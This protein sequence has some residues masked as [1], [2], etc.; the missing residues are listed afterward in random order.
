VAGVVERAAAGATGGAAR[1][2]MTCVGAPTLLAP[3]RPLKIVGE[4][5]SLFDFGALIR[6]T[7]GNP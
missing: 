7:P 5:G 1:R 3:T 6:S 4:P 2:S